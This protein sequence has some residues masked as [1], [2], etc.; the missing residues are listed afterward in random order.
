MEPS[1]AVKLAAIQ[2]RPPKGD[3]VSARAALVDLVNRAGS[4][5]AR[6]IVAP[7]MA[8]SGYLWP[9][10][11]ALLPHAESPEGPTFQALAPLARA[12]GA[13]IVV[14]FPER[15]REGL[16]NAAMVIDHEGRLVDVYRKILLYEADRPWALTGARRPIYDTPVGRVSP[17]I[18]MDLNDDGFALHLLRERP[19]VVA[20]CT[21]WV[22]EG[23]DVLPYW[24]YRLAGWQGWFVAADTWGRDGHIE[25]H[26]RS[27]ILGPEGHPRAIARK[28]GDDVL[29]VE[30][31][32]S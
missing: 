20:F 17:A 9:S 12:H 5:G 14:G 15:A 23:V 6:L 4:G 21:N 19:D 30:T 16:Y 29:L 7:E 32:Q 3:P 28:E 26:G 11:E 13:W 27:A 22:E 8:T 2:Y 18:C 1:K 24:T 31:S 10:A 25:F